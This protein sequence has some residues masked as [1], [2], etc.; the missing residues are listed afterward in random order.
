MIMTVQGN[1]KTLI[2]GI[3]K[4]WE[5]KK[6]KNRGN[7]QLIQKKNEKSQKLGWFNKIEKSQELG[8]FKINRK[9]KKPK[10]II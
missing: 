9:F 3:Q 6:S 7:Y 2:W 8:Q 5:L 10:K 1:K 4:L